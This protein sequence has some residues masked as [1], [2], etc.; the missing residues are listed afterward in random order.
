MRGRW[1]RNILEP[2]AANSTSNSDLEDSELGTSLEFVKK[3]I[4]GHE[5]YAPSVDME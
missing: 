4:P 5:H 1:P 2:F 3:A